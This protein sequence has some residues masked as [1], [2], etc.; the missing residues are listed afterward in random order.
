MLFIPQK[1]GVSRISES[2]FT[3]VMSWVDGMMSSSSADDYWVIRMSTTPSLSIDNLEHFIGREIA[4]SPWMTVEQERIDLFAQVTED[5]DPM[6]IDPEWAAS[7]G[8][9]GGTVLAGMHLLALLPRLTRGAGLSIDGV[10]LAM[11]YGFNRVR[12]VAPLPVRAEFRNRM[13]L[14]AVERRKDGKAIIVS[15][16]TMQRRDGERPVF[17]AEWVNLLWPAPALGRAV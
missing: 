5:P 7:N 17:V 4:L 3:F 10:R 9:Y 8:P 13:D 12:F 1:Y 6:H 14:L 15:R 2:E 11:N 16:N